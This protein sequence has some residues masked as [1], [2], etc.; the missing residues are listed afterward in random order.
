MAFSVSSSVNFTHESTRATV[1]LR[2]CTSPP[3][4]GLSSQSV[5]FKSGTDV[6]IKPGLLFSDE[7][8]RTT[9]LSYTRTQVMGNYKPVKEVDRVYRT[10]FLLLHFTMLAVHEKQVAQIQTVSRTNWNVQI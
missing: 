6:I 9:G 4:H 2:V 3:P 5:L 7:T 8:L 10:L 1:S